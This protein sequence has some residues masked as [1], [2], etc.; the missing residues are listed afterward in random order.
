M[1]MASGQPQQLQSSDALALGT[2]AS[3]TLTNCT[4]LPESG[5]TSLVADLAL[6][7][8][9]A[10]PTFTG[11]VVLPSGQALIAA[12]LGTPASGTLNDSLT[13]GHDL[14][15]VPNQTGG[16]TK[17]FV[18]G[19]AVNISTTT[20]TGDV[21]TGL[22]TGTLSNSTKYD[23]RVKLD[24]TNAADANGMKVTINGGG[25]GATLMAA[26][27]VTSTAVAL[28]NATMNTI[29]TLSSAFVTASGI[30]G[31]VIID[32]W[33][34]TGAT[35]AVVNV[36]CAKVTG[37]TATVAVGSYLWVRKADT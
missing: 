29:D 26:L 33:F 19:S 17:Y 4:G 15:A 14:T 6:K 30:R 23:F 20:G 12:A 37:N 11:T 13:Y 8:P 9:L 27:M 18:T 34:T 2:P 25:S 36:K 28:V 7:A 1:V 24:V 10:S 35:A 5:V 3:G 32:G 22:T 16:W 31:I 21:V